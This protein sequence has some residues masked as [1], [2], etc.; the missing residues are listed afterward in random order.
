[1]TSQVT[2]KH[3]FI[4]GMFV[5]LY[6]LVSTISTIHSVSFFALSNDTTT[7]LMAWTLALAFEIGQMGAL[8]GLLILD[9]TNKFIVWSLF[10]ILTLFQIQANT[11]YAY[12][13][14]HSFNGW[15]ELFGINE[16][17]AI[18]KKRI[19]AFV[20]GGVLPLIALG[21]IKSLMDYIKPSDVKP[22][23][24][25]ETKAEQPIEAPAAL[26]AV[27]NTLENTNHLNSTALVN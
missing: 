7:P 18:F 10:I 11:F 15:T 27:S 5:G 23:E 13:H 17:D 4:I 12:E 26:E 9:R 21:F 16:E 6:L 1:M 19:L 2:L 25:I 3:K 20:S 8:A 24:T 22:V 14:L